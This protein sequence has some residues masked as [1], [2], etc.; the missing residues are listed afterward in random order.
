MI[1]HP[2]DNLGN[3][4]AFSLRI[5]CNLNENLIKSFDF[6]RNYELSQS[7]TL[8]AIMHEC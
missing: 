3:G 1:V 8:D 6:L 4:K 7:Q 2:S 5:S